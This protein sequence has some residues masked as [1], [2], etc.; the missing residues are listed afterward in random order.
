MVLIEAANYFKRN[1]IRFKN[2]SNMVFDGTK[3]MQKIITLTVNPLVDKNTTV[4]GLRPDTNLAATQ[5]FYHAGGGGINVSRAIHNLGGSSVALFLEGGRTGAHLANL[6]GSAGIPIKTVH[7]AS[8][9]RENFAVKDTVTQLDYRFSMPGPFVKEAE[10]KAC[11]TAV[12]GILNPGDYLVASG[13]LTTGIP[14]DFYLQLANIAEAKGAKLVLDTKGK[15]LLEAIKG[16]IYLLKPNLAELSE[17]CGVSYISYSELEPLAKNFINRHSCEF[18]V[19]SLGAKGALLVSAQNTA[20]IPGVVVSQ[21]SIIGAGDSMVAGMV[22]SSLQGAT[23]LEMAQ[24]GVACGTATTMRPGTKLC[25]KEDVE[26]IY[27]W[28]QLR[29]KETNK[30]F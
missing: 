10:W 16:R 1:L 19:V 4:V 23:P 27:E 2:K 21:Q 6:L 26:G 7:I 15:A 25:K 3:E 12:E 30:N 5:A 28:I 9:T 11:L 8:H 24:Y 22:C 29:E 18:M 17:L 13:K 14:D 20:Y